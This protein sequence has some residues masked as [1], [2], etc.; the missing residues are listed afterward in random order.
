MV[1]SSQR[2]K[3]IKPM[4]KYKIICLIGEAGSGK[5]YLLH[6]LLKESTQFNEIISC[7]TRPIRDKEIDGVNYHYI[8]K[9]QFLAMEQEGLML[10]TSQFN[11]WFYGTPKTSLS[12]NKINIGVFNPQ[13]IRNLLKNENVDIIVYYIKAGDKTRLIR[14]LYRENNPNVEEIV[15]RFQTD[16][17]DFK[18]LNF[19]Y[20]TLPNEN[21]TDATESIRAIL[22]NILI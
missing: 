1:K 13:G 5:D 8:T 7:T 22:N 4:N 19:D 18:E 20:T 10:E 6:R 15:R 14:Q 11:G 12:L 2:Q 3:G 16:K 9:E 17:K 21:A